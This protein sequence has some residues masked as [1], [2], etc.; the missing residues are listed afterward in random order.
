MLI[1]QSTKVLFEVFNIKND[2]CYIFD[3]F[4]IFE[5]CSYL[6]EDIR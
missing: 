6:L 5:A 2:V 1:S 3:R 4:D